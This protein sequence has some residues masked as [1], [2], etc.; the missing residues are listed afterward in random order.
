MEREEEMSSI[1]EYILN[2]V[3]KVCETC[4]NVAQIRVKGSVY[5]RCTFKLCR[6]EQSVFH[7]T[8]LSNSKLKPIKVLEIIKCWLSKLSLSLI[9]E[10]V[11]T[12]RKTVSKILLRLKKLTGKKYIESLPVIG[13]PGI[14][15]EIDESKFGKRKYHRGHRVDGV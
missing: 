6:K 5:H 7:N 4:G 13:G 14:I 3:P 1:F 12:S 2:R 9:A 10:F 11:G 15:V 8:L